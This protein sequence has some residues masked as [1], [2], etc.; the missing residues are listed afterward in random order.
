MYG[1]AHL[2]DPRDVHHALDEAIRV[3]RPGGVILTAFL[4]VHAILFNSYLNGCL[5]AGRKENLGDDGRIR[6]FEEQ[7]FTGYDIAEFEA[8]F[9]GKHVQHLITAA[10]DSILELAEE[11]CNFAMS[12]EKFP[13]FAA[14]HLATYEIRELLDCS[15]SA[16]RSDPMPIRPATPADLARIAEFEVFNYRLDFYPIFRSDEFYFDEMIVPNLMPLS[17][18]FIPDILVYDDGVVKGFLHYGGDEVRRLCVE[19]VMQSQGIGVDLLEYAIRELNEKHL[20]VLEKNPRAIAIYQQHAFRVTEERRLE[21]GR[22]NTS[23][24]W[25]E[26]NRSFPTQHQTIF[27]GTNCVICGE[28]PLDKLNHRNRT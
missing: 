3:T 15:T 23:S 7:L 2:Y 20:W 22:R 25:K 19:P 9:A 21:G 16:G 26:N 17:A 11:R 27:A 24:G 28:T 14:H 5:L 6:H 18:D 10:A 13:A 4:S 8:L 1:V 12:D